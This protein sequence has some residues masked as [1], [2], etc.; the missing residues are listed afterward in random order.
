M[1]VML[2]VYGVSGHGS[3]TFRWSLIR[4]FTFWSEVNR[5]EMWGDC[6]ISVGYNGLVVV[7]VVEGGSGS[8]TGK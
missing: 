2:I 8:A 4:M 3:S 6:E 7:L 5:M 1:I